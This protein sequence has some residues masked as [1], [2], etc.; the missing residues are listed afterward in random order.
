HRRAAVARARSR[1]ARALRLGDDPIPST[2]GGRRRP[3]PLRHGR[4]GR[5]PGRAG[6]VPGMGGDRR[7][8]LR[9]AGPDGRRAAGRGEGRGAGGGTVDEVLGGGRAVGGETGGRGAERVRDRV[10]EALLI[11]LAPPTLE[12]LERRLRGRGTETE[13]SI[14]RRL[15][16]AARELG[17]SGWFAARVTKDDVDRAKEEVCA[18][19]KD[20][21]TA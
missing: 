18:F 12:E 15:D 3:L 20:T 17:E 11:F 16:L 8:S 10:R 19:I 5:S 2:G 21:S 9:D 4:R 14:H 1:P 6:G 13:A 7:A